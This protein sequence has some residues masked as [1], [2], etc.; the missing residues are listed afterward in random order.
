[1]KV[2]VVILNWNGIAL[3]EKYIPTLVQFSPQAELYV[4]DN[5][6]TDASVSFLEENYPRIHTLRLTENFGFAKGYNEGLKHIEADLYCLLNN[7]VK[8]TNNWLTPM[9]HAFETTEV[10]IAQP[11][12]L[13]LNKPNQFE[14]AGAAGGYIDQYGFPFCRG[15]IFTVCEQNT[16]QYTS[17]ED[18]FWASG[19]CFFI[20]S[21]TWEALGGFD[22]DFF[23]H[24]EEID[25]C[26]RAFNQGYV[27]QSIGASHVYHLG[28]G[29]LRLSPQKTYYN[30]RNSI[31]MMIKN[32]P[33][34]RLFPI[35]FLRLI[36]DGLAGIHYLLKGSP[37]SF[38]K[39]IKAHFYNYLHLMKTLK[40]RGIHRKKTNYYALKSIVW[41]FFVL[42]KSKFSDFK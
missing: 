7:D 24:Q 36:L 30:H 17:T 33:K 28:G 37:S 27:C 32:L 39:V 42:R 23:M 15:R 41:T 38:L 1:M 21:N 10:A 8:V 22:E 34:N 35:L 14:Y 40:K 9:I 16:N 18:C 5:A 31:L 13:D 20:R 6:S 2:A 12:I 25:L 4:I 11:H 26:W 19:A 3:L 29:S